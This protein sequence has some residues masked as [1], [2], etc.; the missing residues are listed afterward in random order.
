MIRS[1]SLLIN[2][3]FRK[4]NLDSV[5]HYHGTM[6]PYLFIY[7]IIYCSVHRLQME[8]VKIGKAMFCIIISGATIHNKVSVGVFYF[9][10]SLI[11]DKGEKF[12][13]EKLLRAKNELTRV[14]Q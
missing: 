6:I 8:A 2:Q 14:S 13:V 5:K 9:Y 12:T 3:S 10:A 4:Y 7:L 1:E 11:K